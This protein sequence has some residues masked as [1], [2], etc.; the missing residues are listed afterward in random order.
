MHNELLAPPCASFL[1]SLSFIFKEKTMHIS[2]QVNRKKKGGE[3]PTPFFCSKY[4]LIKPDTHL[5]SKVHE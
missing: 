4:A 2:M 3:E 5:E 1:K